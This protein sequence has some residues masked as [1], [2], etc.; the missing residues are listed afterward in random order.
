MS[1]YHV[2]L[3]ELKTL[4]DRAEHTQGRWQRR[5][6][7]RLVGWI[8][9]IR[10]RWDLMGGHDEE[11]HSPGGGHRFHFHHQLAVYSIHTVSQCSSSSSSGVFLQWLH[12]HRSMEVQLYVYDLSKVSSRS[13]A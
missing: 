13:S 1:H 6:Q 9:K 2:D 11:R 4:S 8:D 10:W 7:R 5:V 12:Q 3:A